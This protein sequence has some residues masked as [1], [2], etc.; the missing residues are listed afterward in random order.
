VQ[1]IDT[2]FERD[3]KMHAAQRILVACLI[4]L[5]TVAFADVYTLNPP[6][7]LAISNFTYTGLTLTGTVSNITD[8]GNCQSSP[9]FAVLNFYEDANGFNVNDGL[10]NTYLAGVEVADQIYPSGA[11]GQFE[12]DQLF[13]VTIDD[14]TL[15]SALEGQSP[16]SFGPV[17][18]M[19]LHEFSYTPGSEPYAIADLTPAA[20]PVPEPVSLT[21]LLSGLAAGFARKRLAGKKS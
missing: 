12:V 8:F 3:E 20:S 2:K 13:D 1:V 15:W 5:P 19:D 4:C 16:S 6:P 21:L 9:C 7:D 10:G 11:P 17:V 14:T 18:V